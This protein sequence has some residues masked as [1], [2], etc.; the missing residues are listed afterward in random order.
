MT[1]VML[2][3]E[4]SFFKSPQEMLAHSFLNAGLYFVYPT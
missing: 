4:N 3:L 2:N 1:E